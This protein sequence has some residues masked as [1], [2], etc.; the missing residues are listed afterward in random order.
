MFCALL[1]SRQHDLVWIAVAPRLI[2]G[3]LFA[4]L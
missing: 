2:A 1:T 4:R 3:L